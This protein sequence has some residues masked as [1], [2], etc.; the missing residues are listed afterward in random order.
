MSKLLVHGAWVCTEQDGRQALIENG[1]VGIDGDKIAYV[2]KDRPAGYEDAEL[3]E[4]RYGLVMPGLVDLHYHSDSP[5]T[6]GFQEDCGSE[7][8]YG[9]ILYEYLT[10]IYAATTV[11]EWRAIANLTF[12]EMISGGV[13]TC[14]EFN[15]YYPEEMVVDQ[16]EARRLVRADEY[17]P[18]YQRSHGL[19]PTEGRLPHD[20]LRR[21]E[22]LHP[23][24]LQALPHRELPVRAGVR[25]V[26]VK[27]DRRGRPAGQAFVR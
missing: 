3:I 22:A 12:M 8:L 13:T 2:G 15:S 4:R 25:R 27:P 5:A 7:H 23:E 14:V 16:R 24:R 11:D 1:Y 21:K 6:K 10:A 20:F 19:P 26:P 18:V 9:S 17:H